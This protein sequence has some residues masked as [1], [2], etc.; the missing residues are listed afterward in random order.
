[1]I[2]F[3]FNFK[4][5]KQISEICT[6]SKADHYTLFYSSL[7]KIHKSLCL[8]RNPNGPNLADWRSFDDNTDHPFMNL[9]ASNISLGTNYRKEYTDF[10]NQKL[11]YIFQHRCDENS[12]AL[13]IVG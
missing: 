4:E 10:W 1:M 12:C 5:D 8:T 3:T 11:P 6:F 2:D 13:P 7:L 9:Q